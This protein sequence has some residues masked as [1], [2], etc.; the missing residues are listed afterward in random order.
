MS[1]S[2]N[3]LQN[4]KQKAKGLF[5]A[6]LLNAGRIW[7]VLSELA[8]LPARK[9]VCGF[10]LSLSLGANARWFPNPRSWGRVG[11]PLGEVTY[12]RR[13]QNTRSIFG[14]S[15]CSLCC[16][17]HRIP[18]PSRR[19]CAGGWSLAGKTQTPG[20]LAHAGERVCCGVWWVG[21]VS[22]ACEGVGRREGR[23]NTGSFEP[24]VSRAASCSPA[25]LHE[26]SSPWDFRECLQSAPL[27]IRPNPPTLQGRCRTCLPPVCGQGA[28]CSSWAGT[29]V[30]ERGQ[31]GRA[32]AT[33]MGPGSAV[34]RWE[35]KLEGA[36]AIAKI[37]VSRFV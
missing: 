25:R 20:T 26:L 4:E 9:T 29:G 8:V 14:T 15:V 27:G 18:V 22:R 7:L 35:L 13:I 28:G 6:E 16:C 36:W 23:E 19:D 3:Y 37:A 11:P 34:W 2:Y 33:L 30:R 17:P 24:V 32:L 31:V 12:P 10:L 21:T 5:V 1:Y